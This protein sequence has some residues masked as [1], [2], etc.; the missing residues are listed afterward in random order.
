MNTAIALFGYNRPHYFERCIVSLVQNSELFELPVYAF[1]DGGD[2]SRQEEYAAIL[3]DYGL[4][5]TILRC[6]EQNL[7]CGRN[8]IQGRGELFDR[9]KF[10]RV[11]VVEDDVVVAPHY[12]R[13]LQNL[14]DWAEAN[15]DE[16][17]VVSG[18]RCDHLTLEDKHAQR[19]LVTAENTNWI[20]YLM[21]RH[22][23]LGVRDRLYEYSGRFL[24]GRQYG[25]RSGREITQYFKR[26]VSTAAPRQGVRHL[27]E[28]TY[29]NWRVMAARYLRPPFPTGQDACTALA[30]YSSGLVKLALWVNRC[31]H[32]GTHGIHAHPAHREIVSLEQMTLDVFPDDPER[33]EFRCV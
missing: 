26:L 14:A 33:V 15:F 13:V 32:I 3:S 29:A 6:R 21:T 8:L 19:D 23:W 24:E 5:S 31:L 16:V 30:L 27:P 7:G 2:G 1:L 12:F 25:E 28:S 20:S 4:S 9:E 17:G 10:E 11:I 18:F 22:G